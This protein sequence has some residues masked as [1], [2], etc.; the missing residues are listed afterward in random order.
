MKKLLY[1]FG[2][3]FLML[4]SCTEDISTEDRYTYKESTIGAYLESHDQYSEYV[5]LL[6]KMPVSKHTQS[7]LY[8]LLTAR[9]NYTVFAPDNDAIA[10]YLQL[11]ADKGIIP[12]AS[13]DA[14]TDAR[15]LDS[16]QH[17]IVFN[18]IIDS[19]DEDE[20]YMT[21]TFP[22]KG[23]P[24][25]EPN[26]N[27]RKLT[28]SQGDVNPDSIYIN[29][30][31]RMDLKN[32]DIQAINGYVHQMH[33]V[34]APSNESLADKLTEYI[35]SGQVRYLVMAKLIMACGLGD[36]L[37]KVKDEVYEDLYETGDI[38][39]TLPYHDTQGQYGYLPAHR[40]YG[41]T[42]FAETDD[43]WS[44]AIGKDPHDISIADVRNY[45]QQ[46]NLC[47]GAV[48]NE[49]YKNENNALNQFVTY[50]IL[51][52]NIPKDRLVIHY[53]EIGY[54]YETQQGN[55]LPVSEIYTT[56]GKRRLLKIYESKETKGVIYLNRFPNLDN[57]RRGNYHELSC[58]PDK[59][60][61]AIEMPED[62]DEY[63]FVNAI[64]Y[65]INS[66]LAYDDATRDNFQKQ[67]LRFDSSSMFPEFMNNDLRANRRKDVKS[68]N[69][70]IPATNIYPYLQDVIIE[71]NSYFY[72]LTG[73]GDGWNNYQ[74]D[75]FN[76]V[77]NYDMTYRLPPVPRRGTYEIRYLVGA[78]SNWRSM[79]QVY[80]GTDLNNLVAQGI[81][82]DLRMGG[83]ARY[84]LTASYPSIV[85]WEPDEED[86]DINAEVDKKMRANGYMK[87]PA[88]YIV[89]SPR[90][91]PARDNSRA[92]RKIIVTRMMDPDQVYYLKFKSVLDNEKLQFYMD[93]IEYCPKEIYDNPQTPEDIW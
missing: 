56:M 78:G 74:G 43:F 16:I 80:F 85:G 57:G 22:T 49:D 42:L 62:L 93:Y 82:L 69:V 86:D 87:A 68:K 4:V 17:V 14:F 25:K 35:S 27:D 65:P 84:T 15:V 66:V 28:V 20:P 5:E 60:G 81:P 9:G 61:I 38:S 52:M 44:T 79:C 34:I 46:H 8:Q 55:F 21:S 32:R 63:T 13:W 70:G 3:A 39:P 90:K 31:Y 37:S 75:E 12:E 7:T 59:E 36:T 19:G 30:T 67:R 24:F 71:E 73:Y 54:D 91:G 26:L 41:F 50:H 23:N 1:A 29:S 47:P 10:E 53:N 76:V 11:Q 6:K 58:D 40:K 92:V 64:I 18:S 77:G 51:P 2:A 33:D 45:I 83:E 89:N 88:S 48:D 72:Y